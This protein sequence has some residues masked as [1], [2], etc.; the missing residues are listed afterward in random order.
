[1]EKENFKSQAYND[2]EAYKKEHPE[3]SDIPSAKLLQNYEEDM[4]RFIIGLFK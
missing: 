4:T 2:W 1:M 3:I